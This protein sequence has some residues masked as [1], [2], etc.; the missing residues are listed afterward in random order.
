VGWGVFL[1][2]RDALLPE[3]SQ[4][5]MGSQGKEIRKGRL[6]KFDQGGGGWLGG[7]GVLKRGCQR[8]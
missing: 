5:H 1:L 3:A 6:K 8:F 4:R 7:G 2:K